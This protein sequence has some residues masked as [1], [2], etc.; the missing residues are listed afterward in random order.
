MSSSTGGGGGGPD[1]AEWPGFEEFEVV[2]GG[3]VG[4]VG[5]VAAVLEVIGAVLVGG[6]DTER[7]RLKNE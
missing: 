4:A 1:D 7:L 5:L 2:I 6:L 3:D